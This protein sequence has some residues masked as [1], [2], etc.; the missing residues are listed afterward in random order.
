MTTT[1]TAAAN[2]NNNCS[3]R[4]QKENER[5]LKDRQMEYAISEGKKPCGT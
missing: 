1:S 2:N 4:P 3:S 5:K